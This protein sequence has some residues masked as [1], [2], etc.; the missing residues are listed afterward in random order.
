MKKFILWAQK[1]DNDLAGSIYGRS[2]CLFDLISKSDDLMCHR[3]EYKHIVIYE[4]K[5][6][7]NFKEVQRIW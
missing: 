3:K 5:D 7:A 2:D 6:Y 4:V 1:Y